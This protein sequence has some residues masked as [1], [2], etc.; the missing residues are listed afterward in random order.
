MER[1]HKTSQN[2][3]ALAPIVLIE[4]SILLIHGQKLMLDADLARLYGVSTKRLNEQVRRDR[5]RFPQDFMFQLSRNEKAQVVANCDHLRDLKFSATLPL[6]FTEHGAI[7]VVSVLNTQREIHVS[8]Y[9]VR[10][11]VKLRQMAVDR[12]EVSPRV[13]E[14]ER[15]FSRHEE[16]FEDVFDAIPQMMTPPPTPKATADRPQRRN[17]QMRGL[18]PEPSLK[19]EA[20]RRKVATFSATVTAGGRVLCARKLLKKLAGTTGLEPATS[21]VTAN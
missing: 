19:V 20:K 21:C 7:M 3:S 16:K 4:R 18:N 15:K 2:E 8:A 11:F 12:E 17:K 14:L 9:V 5:E 1:A 10:A 6:A 13:D